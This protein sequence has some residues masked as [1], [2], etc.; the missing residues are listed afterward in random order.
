MARNKN[1]FS[2]A[3][4]SARG[5]ESPIDHEGIA[6]GVIRSG[7]SPAQKIKAI[8]NHPTMPTAMK[9]WALDTITKIHGGG[10]GGIGLSAVESAAAKPAAESNPTSEKRANPFPKGTALHEYHEINPKPHAANI[11]PPVQIHPTFDSYAE[12]E[13]K[14]TPEQVYQNN[15]A[16]KAG[17][18]FD[19]IQKVKQ[20]Q[21]RAEKT[22]RVP[23][24]AGS[25]RGSRAPKITARTRGVYVPQTIRTNEFAQKLT[26]AHSQLTH[27]TNSLHGLNIAPEAAYG[28]NAAK[29]NIS[30]GLASI[31]KGN[32]LKDGY[33]EGNTLYR[34]PQAAHFHYISAHKSLQEAHDLLADSS[35]Q[36]ELRKNNISAELPSRTLSE[37]KTHIPSLPVAKKPAKSYSGMAIGGYQSITAEEL[38][39]KTSQ[40]SIENIEKV[41]G[42]DS[43]LSRSGRATIKGYPRKNKFIDRI[44]NRRVSDADL[45][46]PATEE[47][48]LPKPTGFAPRSEDPRARGSDARVDINFTGGTP[49]EGKMPTFEGTPEGK[50]VRRKRGK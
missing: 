3:S 4:D 25:S 13:I 48:P 27:M 31:L 21:E 34:S 28:L 42:K 29:N 44:E 20:Q 41:T 33:K 19:A 47:N 18:E 38:K 14:L 37:L 1:D 7:Q 30:E 11:R 2:G 35:I 46:K 43:V 24:S 8:T 39:D 36:S 22:G 32:E 6:M 10:G 17:K 26:E 16:E 50:P 9:N 40:K 49:T 12:K 15:V 45:A 23:G 5:A